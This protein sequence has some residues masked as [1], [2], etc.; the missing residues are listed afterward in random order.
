M[1]GLSN[2]ISQLN[3]LMNAEMQNEQTS[4]RMQKMNESEYIN[5]G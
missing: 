3:N 4:P 5:N 2:K 1:D